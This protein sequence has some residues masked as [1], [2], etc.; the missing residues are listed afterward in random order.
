[1]VWLACVLAWTALPVALTAGAGNALTTSTTVPALPPELLTG[2]SVVG[3]VVNSPGA[4]PRTLD[5]NQATAFMQTWVAYSVFQ[6]PP[7]ERPP[8]S[9][10]VSRLS[11]ATDSQGTLL[12]F[13]ASDG[14]NAWVGAPNADAAAK[15]PNNEKW[16]RAPEP[17]RTIAGFEGRLAPTRTPLPLPTTT[18]STTTA[19]GTTAAPSTTKAT[20]SSDNGGLWALVAL[21]AAVI[22]AASAI[23]AVRGRR[24]TQP[25]S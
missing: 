14:T 9:L 6:N 3:A 5:A 18:T 12:I 8:S 25:Q 2:I 23:L 4:K 10:P 7:N 11:V 20:K 13:Y 19:P 16:I 15:P 17:Q 24:R 21:G 1:L 22:V